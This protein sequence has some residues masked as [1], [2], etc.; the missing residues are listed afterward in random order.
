MPRSGQSS[1]LTGRNGFSIQAGGEPGA[2]YGVVFDFADEQNY[3]ALVVNGNG[4]AR[5]YRVE[6]GEEKDWFPLAQ[7]PPVQVGG[8]PN[9]LRVD[10]G[11][12]KMTVRINDEPLIE[13]ADEARGRVGLIARS[14]APGQIVVFQRARL[15][16]SLTP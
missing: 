9:R 4:Y 16:T 10:A 15:W 2:L 3:S 5:A 12:G 6:G 1:R 7:W 11:G 13:M 14:V 8:A